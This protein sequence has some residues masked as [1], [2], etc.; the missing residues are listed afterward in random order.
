MNS[1]DYNEYYVYTEHD[2][3]K[4]Y[5]ESLG[6]KVKEVKRDIWEALNPDYPVGI[7]ELQYRIG[8]SIAFTKLEPDR[9]ERNKEGYLIKYYAMYYFAILRKTNPSMARYCRSQ[10]EKRGIDK[11]HR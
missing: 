5:L 3:V 1:S 7:D 4:P 10:L 8:S 11:E 2:G 6:L 9:R